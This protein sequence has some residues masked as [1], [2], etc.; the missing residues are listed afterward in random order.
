MGQEF[1]LKAL[2]MGAREQRLPDDWR[3]I[4]V[5]THCATFAREPSL[6]AGDAI[7]FYASGWGLI[8]A[9]GQVTSYPYRAEDPSESSWPYR[10]NVRLDHQ[11]AWVHDGS[12]LETLNVGDRDVRVS[13]RRRSHI[14][15]TDAEY[16]AALAALTA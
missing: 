13:M 5:L 1:W 4:T 10:V 7:I 3:S 2:G 16:N 6:K 15:L 12:P 8:F 11:K 14:R 9:A